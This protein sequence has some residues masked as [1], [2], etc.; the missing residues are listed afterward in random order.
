MAEIRHS[1]I[2][3]RD[4]RD[5]LSDD[6]QLTRYLLGELT[7]EEQVEIE[8]R[9]FRDRRYLLEIEAVECDLIDDY[10]RGALSEVERRQFE[11]R[12]LASEKRRRKLEFAKS[13]EAVAGELCKTSKVP[14]PLRPR[15][16]FFN[17]PPAVMLPNP[18]HYQMKI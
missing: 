18:R 6:A 5:D 8:E 15:V 17:S 13:L 9:A 10:V 14:P 4:M 12:F 7:E 1:Y 11:E 3:D 2:R 16:F